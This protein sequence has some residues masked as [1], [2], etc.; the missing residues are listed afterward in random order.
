[1]GIFGG[2]SSTTLTTKNETQTNIDSHD[3][4]ITGGAGGDGASSFVASDSRVTFTDQG[5]IQKM[6]AIT[7]GA[8]SSREKSEKAVL[9]LAGKASQPGADMF[10]KLSMVMGGVF[11]VSLAV[12]GLSMSGGR[13]RGRKK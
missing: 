13:K 9:D 3:K 2:D 11:V 12:V 5:A 10:N 8:L 6:A 7:M 4:T 1:M